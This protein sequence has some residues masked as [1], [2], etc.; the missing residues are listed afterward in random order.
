MLDRH[1]HT[2][3]FNETYYTPLQII[4]IVMGKC[5]DGLCFS[6]TTSCKEGIL[7][8]EV[9]KEIGDTL[10]NIPWSSEIVRPFLW[11]SPHFAKQGVTA[12][13]AMQNLPYKGIKIHPLANRWDLTDTKTMSIAHGLFE[14]A[15]QYKLPVLIHTGEN[16]VDA[17]TVFSRFFPLYP[18]TI[19][20]LAHCRPAE[21]TIPLLQNY[22]NVYGDTAFL[23]V[24]NMQKIK[25][26][27][28]VHKILPGT[29]FPITH[30]FANRYPQGASEITLA[31]Q[32]KRDFALMKKY[33]TIGDRLPV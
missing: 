25:S 30:Y 3:R 31:E 21:E 29:D 13:K 26:K 6:S 12:E 32:Y 16:G 5:K 2:G 14:Y 27:N 19:F 20:I 15:G 9:E 28:L 4:E 1:I 24:E 7:Y 23:S 33:K 8:S 11:Y 17:P 18:E 10:A 22:P